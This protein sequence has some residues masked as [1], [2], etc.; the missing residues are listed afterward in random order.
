MSRPNNLTNQVKFSASYQPVKKR[1]MG[2]LTMFNNWMRIKITPGMRSEIDEGILEYVEKFAGENPTVF[3]VTLA[4]MIRMSWSPDPKIA[5]AAGREIMDRYM[6]K[7]PQTHQM[8]DDT[9]I[10]MEEVVPVSLKEL[11]SEKIKQIEENF[12]EAKK[13]NV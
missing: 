5:F 12:K 8:E 4:N 13:L 11:D 10:E 9:I 7:V 2:K 6:G 1:G 3:D